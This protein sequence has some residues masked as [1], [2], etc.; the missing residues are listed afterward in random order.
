MYLQF[1][2]AKVLR[3]QLGGD[4]RFFTS[5][6]APDYYGAVGMFAIQDPNYNRVKIGNYP[7]VN[8]YANMHLKTCRFYIGCSHVNATSGNMFLTPHMPLNPMSIF[9]GLSWNFFN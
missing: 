8:V 3:V 9:F 5:Y 2:L 1:R 4:L 7:I 6:Y